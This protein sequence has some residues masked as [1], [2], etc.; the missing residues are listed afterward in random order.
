MSFRVEDSSN[1]T[2]SLEPRTIHV[3]INAYNLD[4]N[5]QSYEIK[6]NETINLKDSIW[7]DSQITIT[8]YEIASSFAHTY[9]FCVRTNECYSSIEYLRP[10]INNTYDKTLLKISANMELDPDVQ[11]SGVYD[12]YDLMNLVGTVEYELNGEVK[13]Q[14]I[15]LKEVVPN[16]QPQ[17]N[18]YYIE[19]LKEVE[20][21][22]KITLILKVRNKTYR[23]SLK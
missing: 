15:R 17:T 6:A 4:K 19:L 3:A 22:D 14:T 20:Q 2:S 16:R 8:G 7:K 18:V 10:S 21:A 9:N 1:L 23:Y 5:E 12:F 13:T 11:I